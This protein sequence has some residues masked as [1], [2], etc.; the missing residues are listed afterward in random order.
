MAVFKI[1]I[2]KTKD[3][4]KIKEEKNV[5]IE[6]G[7]EFPGAAAAL[8]ETELDVRRFLGLPTTKDLVYY[9][10]SREDKKILVDKF[11]VDQ[12]FTITDPWFKLILYMGDD[13]VNI[14]HRYFV[15]MQSPTFISDMNKESPQD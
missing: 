13:N 6:V 15:E 9:P 11:M 3:G 10:S 1:Q 4:K 14:H 8:T 7:M 12:I 2:S 5:E